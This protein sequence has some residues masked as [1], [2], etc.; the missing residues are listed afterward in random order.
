M[1]IASSVR[2]P[3]S[4]AEKYKIIREE[5]PEN[6]RA[7]AVSKTVGVEAIRAAYA[8][9]ARDFAEN[10]IQEAIA[11]QE[12]LQDLSDICWHFI[13]HLQGNKAKKAV[14]S[15]DWIHTCDSLKLARRIANLAADM[16]SPPQ[17]CLQVKI[18]PDPNKHG[19]TVPEL[20]AALPE[21]S[22]YEKLHIRGLMTMLPLGLSETEMLAAFQATRDLGDRIAEQNYSNIQMREFSMGMSGDYQLAV[23]AGSTMVRLGQII[24]G[25]RK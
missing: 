18:L 10:R 14:E 12:Q 2:S 17:V 6:V 13:G 7:I 5:L 23:Q 4:V 22:S 21:L 1:N 16:P 8:A 3:N 15:F 25:A 20:M 11:K 9:G 24:F 19:W